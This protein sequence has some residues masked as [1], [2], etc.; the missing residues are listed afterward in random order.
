MDK[1][2]AF[3]CAAKGQTREFHAQNE[4]SVCEGGLGDGSWQGEVVQ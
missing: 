2:E 3:S 4:I 1:T